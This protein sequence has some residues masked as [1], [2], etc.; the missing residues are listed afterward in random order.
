MNKTILLLFALVC[1]SVKGQIYNYTTGKP[2][3]VAAE[4]MLPVTIYTKSGNTFTGYGFINTIYYSSIAIRFVK[5]MPIKPRVKSREWTSYYAEDLIKVKVQYR[6]KDLVLYPARNIEAYGST[7]LYYK[8]HENEST[9]LLCPADHI[10]YID[11]KKYLYIIQKKDSKIA[12]KILIKLGDDT[13]KMSNRVT[14]LFKDCP[15]LKQK[16]KSGAYTKNVTGL[17]EILDY[18]N[19]HCSEQK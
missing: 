15:A 7:Y 12:D 17:I 1:I 10:E 4:K 14:K 2:N 9:V 13:K 5:D 3:G 16:V 8:I 11:Q 18:Y 6:G 19:E